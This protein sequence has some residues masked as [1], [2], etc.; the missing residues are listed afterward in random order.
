MII[1]LV[2][3][4]F[5]CALYLIMYEHYFVFEILQYNYFNLILLF[6]EANYLVQLF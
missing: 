5:L 6:L 2:S 3:K 4:S 1:Y